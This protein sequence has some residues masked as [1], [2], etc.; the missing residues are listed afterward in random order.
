[1]S[2][3]AERSRQRHPQECLW[4]L[5]GPQTRQLLPPLPAAPVL[6]LDRPCGG[7]DYP[8]Q[9]LAHVWVTYVP[10]AVVLLVWPQGARG[11]RHHDCVRD[12]SIEQI[13]YDGEPE[14]RPTFRRLVQAGELP[15][16]YAADDGAALV[17][18]D[19]KFKEAVASRPAAK[20]Y[21]VS[22]GDQEA[23]EEVLTTR[24]LG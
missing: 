8:S 11:E 2:A 19:G 22:P 3:L 15:P 7:L 6:A 18:A 4:P 1:M 5:K 21:R 17:F 24:Y 16:G 20:A 23:N 9:P 13:H 10:A 14:R 12:P